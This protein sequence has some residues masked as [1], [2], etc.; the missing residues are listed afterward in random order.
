ME[1]FVER[2]DPRDD[3]ATHQQAQTRQRLEVFDQAVVVVV[4]RLLHGPTSLRRRSHFTHVDLR[5]A[6]HAV[7]DRCDQADARIAVHGRDHPGQHRRRRHRV[8][9]QQ[10]DQLALGCAE[11][12]IDAAREAEVGRLAQHA[13]RVRKLVGQLGGPVVT[14]VV[15]DQDLEGG[16]AFLGEEAPD[17]GPSVLDSTVAGDDD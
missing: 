15:D 12:G 17:A 2:A 7:A 13:D 1:P 6:L 3:R 11:P 4:E 9:V 5:G 10:P 16:R 14:G 8:V